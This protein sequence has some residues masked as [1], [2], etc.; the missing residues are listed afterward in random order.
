MMRLLKDANVAG[1]RVLLR[2]SLNLPITKEGDVGDLFR[3]QRALPT[4]RYLVEQK[5][6]III[7]GYI[8]REGGTLQ[9]VAD[10]LQ[11]LVPDI[12]ITFSTTPAAEAG[13]EAAALKE[14]EC[15]MLENLRRDLREEKNDEVFAKELAALVDLYVSDAFAEAHRAY[16]SNCG[17]TKLLPSY[18]GFL[19]EEEVR[20][21]S[22][23]LQPP[24]GALAIIGG[25][26]FETKQ[27]LLEK[28]L[29]LYPEI[30]L[31]GALATDMLKA[32][33]MPVGASLVSDLPVPVLIAEDERI[34]IPNDLIAEAQPGASR[35]AHTADIRAHERIVDAGPKTAQ[36]WA[37]KIA[38]APFVLWN[39][40]LGI[41]EQGYVDGTDALAAAIA[42]MQGS[43][44]LGGGDT[45]AAL[46]KFTFD[47]THVFVSTG[48]G[49]MLEFLTNNGSLPAIEVLKN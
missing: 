28:L 25:A 13:S 44:V 11:K 19:L 22:Q 46:S 42:V 45:A 29:G 2:T 49:A 14:G 34:I 41:Y 1:K 43:A 5:A 26:K 9:P 24:T 30:L 7:V 31:G 18:A 23:A 39:G 20:R 47:P 15:L 37:E 8:G 48:G 32:R 4:L 17:I 36:A 35:P 40:P 27:P 10:V 16:A 33:G 21:L 3:L 38:Q 6:K 12:S